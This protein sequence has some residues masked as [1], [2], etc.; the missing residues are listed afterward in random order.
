MIVY[1]VYLGLL[2]TSFALAAQKQHPSYYVEPLDYFRLFCEVTVL[3]MTVCD[4][5]LEVLDF[6]KN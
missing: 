1:L 3:L 4:F 2:T 5:M 6:W